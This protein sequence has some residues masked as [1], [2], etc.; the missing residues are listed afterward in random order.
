MGT[1]HIRVTT[2]RLFCALHPNVKLIDAWDKNKEREDDGERHHAFV[3]VEEVDELAVS[4]LRH[5]M[6]HDECHTVVHP[7]E[8]DAGED[9]TYAVIHPAEEQTDE[10]RMDALGDVEMDEPEDKC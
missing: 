9:G 2:A 3:A 8:E 10:E 5:D 4:H 6:E 7:M 1:F